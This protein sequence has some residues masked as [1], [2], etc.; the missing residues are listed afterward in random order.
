MMQ[1][2]YL[3]AKI[4]ADTA[5]NELNFVENLPKNATT[6]RVLPAAVHRPRVRAGRPVVEEVGETFGRIT[7][8]CLLRIIEYLCVKDI[9]NTLIYA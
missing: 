4:G 8:R 5:E 3:P 2:A 7:R 1:N 9:Y 6:L